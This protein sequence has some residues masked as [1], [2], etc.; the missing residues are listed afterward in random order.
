ML[1]LR[2]SVFL[3]PLIPSIHRCCRCYSWDG[4][5]SPVYFYSFTLCSYSSVWIG[6]QKKESKVIGAPIICAGYTYLSISLGPDNLTL[7]Y[8]RG[9]CALFR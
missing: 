7:L 4:S 1:L 8:L 3:I 5:L 2:S 6:A 9:F